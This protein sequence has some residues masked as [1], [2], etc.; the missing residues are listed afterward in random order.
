MTLEMGKNLFILRQFTCKLDFIIT[1]TYYTVLEVDEL[2]DRAFTQNKYC[3][4]KIVVLQT[5]GRFS[6]SSRLFT[7]TE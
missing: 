5:F 6:R 1:K 3:S 4:L 7:I 2:A